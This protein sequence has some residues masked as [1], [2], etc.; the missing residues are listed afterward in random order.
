MFRKTLEFLRPW[1]VNR[2][3]HLYQLGPRLTPEQYPEALS[4]WFRNRT[5]KKLNLDNPQTF[6]EKI[7]WLKLHDS[8]AAKTALADKHSAK[9]AIARIIGSRHI[10][11]LLGVW[12]KFDDID[13]ARL[14]DKF[15]LKAS[16]GSG[17]NL[18]VEDKSKLNMR[19]ARHKFNKWMQRNLTF[20]GGLEL[21]Y[22]D[23]KPQII[24][25]DYIGI[26]PDHPADCKFY[27]F[28]GEPQLFWMVAYDRHG[29]YRGKF[30][31]LDFTPLPNFYNCDELPGFP[32]RPRY[33]N[34]MA[35]LSRLLSR[36]FIFARV[37]FYEAGGRLYFGEITFTPTSGIL[38]WRG[39]EYNIQFGQMLRLPFED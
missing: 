5:G 7:Q 19:R 33:L 1:F 16:H 9:E 30:Y 2:K 22:K 26:E 8:T 28:N 11:P 34:K 3:T 27:C 23:I 15:A 18:I 10:V 6:D 36:D 37:D 4:Q 24:A 35:E 39:E 31:T 17:W 25:E 14:P 32:Q 29:H 13:F 12:D 21:H 38:P 20:H